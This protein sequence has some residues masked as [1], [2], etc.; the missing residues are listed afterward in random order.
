MRRQASRFEELASAFLLL[1][2]SLFALVIGVAIKALFI[3]L[4]WPWFVPNIFTQAVQNGS[5]PA[6][7]SFWQSFQLVLLLAVL[8]TTGGRS[9]SSKD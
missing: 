6:A 1:G 9:S 7:L 4:A 3:W 8:I 2:A 5:L